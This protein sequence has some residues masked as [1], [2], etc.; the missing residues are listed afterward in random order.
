M[1]IKIEK[2]IPIPPKPGKDSA[3]RNELRRVLKSMKIGNSFIINNSSDYNRI[4]TLAKNMKIGVTFRQFT[5]S[6]HDYRVWKVKR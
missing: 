5:K 3:R 4:R 2:G 6:K 1:S